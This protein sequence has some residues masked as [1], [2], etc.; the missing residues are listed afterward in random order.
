[1]NDTGAN[2]NADPLIVLDGISKVLL[3]EEMRESGYEIG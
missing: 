1:M 3:T 2:K